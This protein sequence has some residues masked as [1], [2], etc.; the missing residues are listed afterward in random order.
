VAQIDNQWMSGVVTSRIR[1]S[2]QGLHHQRRDLQ[3]STYHYLLKYQYS[4]S[5]QVVS[6]FRLHVMYYRVSFS[7]VT[8]FHIEI[9]PKAPKNY[10]FRCPIAFEPLQI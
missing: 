10:T 2:I 7:F 6:D 9:H 3:Q 8:I 1:C 4:T 5:H